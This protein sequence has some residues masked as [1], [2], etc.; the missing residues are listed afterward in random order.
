MMLA[1]LIPIVV[2]L[3]WDALGIGITISLGAMFASPNDV[4]GNVRMKLK[5][6]CLAILRCMF[7]ISI[8]G[9][10]RSSYALLFPGLGVLIFFISYLFVY[11]F[12][13]SLIGFSG[14]FALALCFSCLAVSSLPTSH[15]RLLLVS[16]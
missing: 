9:F 6:I 11:G 5:G 10:I 14:L 2:S 4:S 7:V 1:L 13:S 8:S 16:G 15:R 3:Q 12:R